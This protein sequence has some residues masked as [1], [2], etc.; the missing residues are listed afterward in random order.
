M[1]AKRT[2]A[3]GKAGR[4]RSRRKTAPEAVDG[5]SEADDED[6][7]PSVLICMPWSAP[8]VFADDLKGTCSECGQAIRKRPHAP[9]VDR[10]ICLACYEAICSPDDKHEVT[11]ET[12]AELQDWLR[13]Q[14][15]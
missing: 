7:E 11:P 5:G 3:G 15:H 9:K 12:I 14:R 4:G 6:A 10:T 13:K 8:A 1:A 2:S